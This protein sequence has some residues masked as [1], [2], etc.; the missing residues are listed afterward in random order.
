[1][2]GDTSVPCDAIYI[3]IK[4]LGPSVYIFL[5]LKYHVYHV[6]LDNS[7]SRSPN[8]ERYSHLRISAICK[9]FR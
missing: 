7:L 2:F 4:G 5:L 3:E 8:L 9:F 6:Y 1:M